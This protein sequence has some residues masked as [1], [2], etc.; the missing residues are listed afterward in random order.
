[1]HVVAFP[2]MIIYIVLFPLI[3]IYIGIS[4]LIIKHV[5]RMDIKPE[6]YKLSTVDLNDYLKEYADRD[7]ENEDIQ[8]GIEL[9]QNAIDFQYV[10]LREC[11]Q[12]RNEIKAVGINDTIE[13][14]KRVFEETKHSKLIVYE[15]NIDNINGYIHIND[16][17]H[18]I[19]AIKA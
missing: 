2:M 17:L 9:V 4:E 1:M 15:D 3:F 12:P 5:F 10:K 6:D 18:N 13:E 11:M 19:K 16:L 7:E 14:V 8:Q